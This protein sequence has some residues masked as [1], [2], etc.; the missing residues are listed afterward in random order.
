MPIG[1]AK[2]GDRMASTRAGAVAAAGTGPR[3]ASVPARETRG[4][5]FDRSVGGQGHGLRATRKPVM[6]YTMV[7]ER[8]PRYDARHSW[9]GEFQWPPRTDRYSPVEGPGGSLDGDDW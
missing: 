8:A 7:G 4:L 3:P 6:E 5:K 2:P 1:R 9:M